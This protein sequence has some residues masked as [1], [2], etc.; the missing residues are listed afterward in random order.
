M[1]IYNIDAI[2]VKGMNLPGFIRDTPDTSGAKGL[3]K[4]KNLP[5]IRDIRL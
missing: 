3:I 5:T 1:L 2:A 4:G